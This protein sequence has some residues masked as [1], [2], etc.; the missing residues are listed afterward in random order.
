MT[1]RGA[2]EGAGDFREQIGDGAR[3]VALDGFAGEDH[4]TGIDVIGIYL[5]EVVAGTEELRE[6]V[7]VDGVVG[8]VRGELDR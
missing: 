2:D 5:G 3:V 8:Q 4:R 6:V 7:G 1:S